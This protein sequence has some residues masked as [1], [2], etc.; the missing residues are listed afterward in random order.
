MLKNKISVGIMGILRSFHI[1]NRLA[2]IALI[3][4]S[5]IWGRP[6]KY[7]ELY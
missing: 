6:M 3:I 1:M 4:V 7:L 5:S 2:I